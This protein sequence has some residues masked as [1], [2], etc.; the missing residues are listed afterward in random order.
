MRR[1]LLALVVLLGSLLA[2]PAVH[3]QDHTISLPLILVAPAPTSTPTHTATVTSTSTWTHT[4]TPSRTPTLT[5]TRTA[6]YTRTP[7]R[8]A[9]RTFTPSRTFTPTRT[10]TPTA[11]ATPRPD[12]ELLPNH[13]GY[14]DS[15]G[16]LWLVGEIQNNTSKTLRFMRI[17]AIALDE[18]LNLVDTTWGYVTLDNLGPGDRTCFD[19]VFSDPPESTYYYQFEGITYWADGKIV[20]GLTLVTHSGRQTS[21][22]Y[23]IIG[24]VRN[25]S[26]RQRDF[27]MSVASVYNSAGAMM[28]CDFTY[29][30]STDL[31]PGMTS[32]FKHMVTVRGSKPVQSYRL[33]IEGSEPYL[34]TAKE[35]AGEPT[36]VVLDS[37]PAPLR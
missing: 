21:Y 23:E 24:Q 37:S 5:P 29:V 25:D 20:D 3:T 31:P 19:L 32:S 13:Q 10:R 15:I 18:A 34:A 16:N 22:S 2:V 14:W 12:I 7:T 17:S 28:A 26:W 9:T 11:T 6:T 33:Q 27:V 35:P 4:P 36:R 30:N 8:T 1:T